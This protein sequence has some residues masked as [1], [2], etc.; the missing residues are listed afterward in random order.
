MVV[1]RILNGVFEVAFYCRNRLMISAL[2]KRLVVCLHPN[3]VTA[4]VLCTPERLA[5]SIHEVPQT[6]KRIRCN[7]G[8]FNSDVAVYYDVRRVFAVPQVA[9]GVA[10]TNQPVAYQ[11]LVLIHGH[12]SAHFSLAPPV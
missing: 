8:D 6:A 7:G 4:A 9:N 12:S 2:Q 10:L 11:L 3:I 5:Y 1:K